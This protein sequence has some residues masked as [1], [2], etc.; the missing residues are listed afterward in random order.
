M[1][2]QGLDLVF[3]LQAE[4]QGQ[5]TI[6]KQHLP[7]GREMQPRKV[8]RRVQE[9]F[10]RIEDSVVQGRRLRNVLCWDPRRVAG[11]EVE[12]HGDPEICRDALIEV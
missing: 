3:I 4:E 10:L 12:L 9:G 5:I 11:D 1:I 6:D 2:G 7:L 8:E